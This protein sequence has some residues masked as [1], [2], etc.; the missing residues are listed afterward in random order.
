LWL[1][2]R[3]RSRMIC[4]FRQIRGAIPEAYTP[5]WVVPELR[6][7][8]ACHWSEKALYLLFLPVDILT[9]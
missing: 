6:S 2:A 9:P 4:R 7:W 5:L 3:I 1:S 8:A